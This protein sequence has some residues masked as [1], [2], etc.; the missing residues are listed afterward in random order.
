MKVIKQGWMASYK[1]AENPNCR[2]GGAIF[3][4]KLLA[5]EANM[6]SQDKLVDI[7]Y[8]NGRKKCLQPEH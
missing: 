6:L 8:L 7:V 1:D 2:I 3:P 4:T 5:Q